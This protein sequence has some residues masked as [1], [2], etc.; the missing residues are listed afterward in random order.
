M[1]IDEFKNEVT[2]LGINITSEQL[3]KLEIYCDFLNIINIQT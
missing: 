1:N 2:K 3:N